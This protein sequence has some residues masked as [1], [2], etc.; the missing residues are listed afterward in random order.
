[1]IFLTSFDDISLK[2]RIQAF[3]K[4]QVDDA[5]TIFTMLSAL[6]MALDVRNGKSIGLEI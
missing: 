6:E 2:V 1:M 5:G 4:I 3:R